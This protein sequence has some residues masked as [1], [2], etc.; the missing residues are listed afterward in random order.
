[1]KK[2]EK[3]IPW[4]KGKKTDPVLR[5]WS[6]VEKTDYCWNWKGFQNKGYGTFKINDDVVQAHRFSYELIKG[7]IP[8]GLE[9]DHL[10]RNP[11]C[12]NPDHLEAVTPKE[13]ILRGIGACAENARKT[14][15]PKGHPLTEENLVKY[16]LKRG[17]RSCKICQY[18][19]NLAYQHRKGVKP[20]K[21]IKH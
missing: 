12:V 5:F 20:R 13:N 1:M 10:C 9:L 11:S 4:N 19:N 16:S 6:H 21:R 15:C 8:E 3:R 7:K 17:Y 18:Q 2:E 14:H